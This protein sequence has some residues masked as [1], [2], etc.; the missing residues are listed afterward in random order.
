MLHQLHSAASYEMFSTTR[1][2]RQRVGAQ[3]VQGKES[4]GVVPLPL[5][6]LYRLWAMWHFFAY[7]LLNQRGASTTRIAVRNTLLRPTVTCSPN[8]VLVGS[9]GRPGNP[10]DSAKAESFMKTLKVEAVYLMGYETFEDVTADL[11]RF[12]DELY[13]TRRL[14]SA[15]GY[16]SP[17]QF[18]DHH[19]RQTVKTTA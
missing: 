17:A 11:P 8:T 12:V 1:I 16:P 9:M 7:R 6:R 10:Y 14:H 18:E 13:N 2:A 19:A 3:I 15:L 4:I 5:S